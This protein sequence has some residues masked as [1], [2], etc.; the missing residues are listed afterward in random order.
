VRAV[1]NDGLVDEFNE[2]NE[3]YELF[4]VETR[5]NNTKI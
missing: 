3:D 5:A 2:L 1:E 4:L